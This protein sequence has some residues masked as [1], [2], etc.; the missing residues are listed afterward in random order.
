M[1]RF[2]W[3]RSAGEDDQ[4]SPPDDN[5]P[6]RSQGSSNSSSRGGS[7]K[8]ANKSRE[9]SPARLGEATGSAG[10]A[11]AAAVAASNKKMLKIGANVRFRGD[12]MECNTVVLCG[13]LQVS[14]QRQQDDDDDSC[15]F[16]Y[17][18][19]FFRC[20]FAFLSDDGTWGRGGEN[21]APEVE[22]T[23]HPSR[24]RAAQATVTF[25]RRFRRP[26]SG[27]RPSPLA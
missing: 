3:S 11:G 6:A 9:Q 24:V 13:R 18:I 20:V 21:K 7:L 8:S 14:G 25:A 17:E 10:G 1:K 23:F 19:V 2:G 5:S 26:G 22:V 4:P 16:F 12:V 27:L 15:V